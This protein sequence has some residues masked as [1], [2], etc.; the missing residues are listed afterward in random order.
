VHS[1]ILLETKIAL[2]AAVIFA[3]KNLQ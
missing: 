2:E 3:N 1:S